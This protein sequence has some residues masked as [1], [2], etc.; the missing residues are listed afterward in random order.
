M[1]LFMFVPMFGSLVTFR[2][3]RNAAF[4][5]PNASADASHSQ[6]WVSLGLR[7]SALAAGAPILWLNF[8]YLTQPGALQSDC[9]HTGEVHLVVF[10][11]T[12]RYKTHQE[13][14]LTRCETA[15]VA[16]DYSH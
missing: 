14:P 13:L 4:V 5:R 6:G 16:R 7:K 15:A 3:S 11:H 9:C 8:M 2:I 1:P 10:A 12:S